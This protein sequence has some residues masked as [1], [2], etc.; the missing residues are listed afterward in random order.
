MTTS[1]YKRQNSQLEGELAAARGQTEMA[2]KIK[3]KTAERFPFVDQSKDKRRI[4]NKGGS[5][6]K[7][8]IIEV[9]ALLDLAIKMLSC[10][11]A[12]GYLG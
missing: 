9:A 8:L 7:Y 11:L 5:S 1:I 2:R 6:V 10:T 12:L 4:D 3:T